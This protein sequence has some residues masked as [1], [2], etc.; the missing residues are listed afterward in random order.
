MD[1]PVAQPA[2]RVQPFHDDF[3]IHLNLHDS[4]L[5][6]QARIPDGLRTVCWGGIGHC[7]RCHS[8]GLFVPQ[9]TLARQFDCHGDTRL[10]R[11]S[12]PDPPHPPRGSVGGR[13]V[14]IPPPAFSQPKTLGNTVWHTMEGS[15]HSPPITSY[16]ILPSSGLPSSFP[17]DSRRIV[18]GATWGQYLDRR[19][20]TY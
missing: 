6:F 12:N 9:K 16:V 2:T 8:G 4:H 17:S 13:S 10:K 14:R 1:E 20:G 15:N 5:I 19:M 18:R 3:C 11:S 7:H